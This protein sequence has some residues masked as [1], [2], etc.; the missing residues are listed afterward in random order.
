[1]SLF[2]LKFIKFCIYGL[3]SHID[4]TSARQILVIKKY[5]ERH[6]YYEKIITTIQTNTF[7]MILLNFK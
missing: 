3:Y 6:Y 1:M 4:V 5:D 2:F 7:M